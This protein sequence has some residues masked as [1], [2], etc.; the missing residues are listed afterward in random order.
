[1]KPFEYKCWYEMKQKT[2]TVQFPR[3][4]KISEYKP[5]DIRSQK[6]IISRYYLPK[7]AGIHSSSRWCMLCWLGGSVA[8]VVTGWCFLHSLRTGFEDNLENGLF[9]SHTVNTHHAFG[10]AKEKVRNK[11]RTS[12]LQWVLIGVLMTE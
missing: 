8:A 9:T 12:R 11:F 4:H 1:M 3:I 6:Y 2:M 7:M 5:A 10:L